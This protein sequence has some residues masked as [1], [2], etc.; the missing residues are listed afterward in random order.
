MVSAL[1]DR[2]RIVEARNGVEALEQARLVLPDVVL[3]DMM[4]PGKSGLE[5]LDELRSDPDLAGTPVVMLTARTQASDRQAAA[6][7]DVFLPKPFSLAGLASTIETLLG[8][9]DATG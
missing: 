5:V 9:H 3:L 4:M 2:Y 6:A 8:R 1:G 7:A